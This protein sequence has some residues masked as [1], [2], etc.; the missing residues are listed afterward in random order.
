MS[1]ASNYNTRGRAA[2][3]LVER[4]PRVAGARAREHRRPDSRRAPAARTERPD[5]AGQRGAGLDPP[6]LDRVAGDPGRALKAA[7]RAARTRQRSL[8]CGQRGW[9]VQ[10]AR[11]MQRIRHL[12]L[13]RRARPPA[14]VDVGNR[15]EQHPRV[16]MARRREQLR[17]GRDL[18][19]A[20]EVHHAHLVAHVA[21][22]GE[23]VRDE[24]VGEALPRC[25]SFMMLST[26]ACTE[27]SSAEVGSSQTRNSGSV[28]SAR[29]IEMRCRWPPE[30]WC[31]NF[32]ASAAAS[33]TE[34]S[35][36]A[37]RSAS[38]RSFSAA[39]AAFGEAVLAQRLGDDVLH[40][41]AR[42]EARV[43][44]LEDH[45]H[46]PA[47]A[48]SAGPCRR[49]RRRRRRPGRASARTARPAGAPPC[50]CRS[51]IRRPAPASC[52]GRS[53]KATSSTAWTNCRGLRSTTRLSQGAE[54]SK[55]LARPSTSTSG[56][57]ALR[58]LAHERRLMPPPATALHA[59]SRRPAWRRRAAGRA[60]RPGSDRRPAGSAG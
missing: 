34:L 14:H 53:L 5:G 8:A 21:H 51:P 1:M 6:F 60:A 47:H 23:V 12:A 59:A 37:T 58:L 16:G 33:P 3:V 17:L 40:L 45:L 41:P 4:R 43:R 48:S 50:S 10:P 26:C 42:I 49:C 9:K 18:D 28:A 19:D 24:E 30:N 52:R 32:S 39:R 31:G 15:V 20:A 11:R 54:T 27:T 56:V 55:V 36:S 2:E 22:D 46:A 13:H 29:A 7:A 25:R 35:S 44:V 57:S 38:R